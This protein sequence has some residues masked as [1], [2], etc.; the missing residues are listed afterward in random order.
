V[1]FAAFTLAD[2]VVGDS[3]G[4]DNRIVDPGGPGLQDAPAPAPAPA[5]GV[6]GMLG[7]LLA[8]LGLARRRLR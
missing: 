7:S 2:N 6:W 4:D 3:T 5:L 1:G 8:L